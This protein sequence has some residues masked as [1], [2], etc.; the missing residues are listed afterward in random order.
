MSIL[1]YE[2][3]KCLNGL[4]KRLLFIFIRKSFIAKEHN[5]IT[6]DTG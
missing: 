6:G 2:R 1:L 3:A 5:K 4:R